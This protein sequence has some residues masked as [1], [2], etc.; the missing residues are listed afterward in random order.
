MIVVCACSLTILFPFPPQR[1]S[2][3]G[4]IPRDAR[5]RY[6]ILLNK[7]LAKKAKNQE[8]KRKADEHRVDHMQRLVDRCWQSKV[9][10]CV[11]VPAVAGGVVGGTSG[12]IIAALNEDD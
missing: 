7:T 10:V 11:D 1:C 4:S 12:G 5:D 9:D 8:K 3:Y 6:I 2:A